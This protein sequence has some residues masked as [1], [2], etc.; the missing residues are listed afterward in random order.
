MTFGIITDSASNLP[1]P[2]ID[3]YDLQI[4]AL[5][6]NIEGELYRSYLKGSSIDLKQFY[7]MMR[8]GK[9]IRTSLPSKQEA[10]DLLRGQ[11][12]KG[13][14]VLYL[15]F[16]SALSGTYEVISAHLRQVA[17]RDY[18]ERRLF[19]V[20]TLAAAL[21]QGLFVLEA[22]KRREAGETLDEVA[23][24]AAGH[25]LNFAHW[26]TVDNLNYLQRGGRLSKGVAIAGTLLNIK[27]VLHV[28]DV[29]RLVPV[30]KVR[31]RKKSLQSLIEHFVQGASEPK[32]QQVV[33]I[34][35]GDCIEEAQFVAAQLKE[36]Y[37]IAD[38]VI[39]YLDPVIGAHAGPG[40]VALFFKTDRQR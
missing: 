19:C 12:D 25:C 1:E 28:D 24:W 31:G 40:T 2:I 30:E 6:F 39:N 16:D 36:R 9:L 13:L 7:D 37:G 3:H 5:E 23:Q 18:P 15:G 20:D 21:G 27:P 32:G 4:M 34:S 11:F 38:P 33:A 14:D 26:F 22:A 35:H 8:D 10:E 17:E 29:G